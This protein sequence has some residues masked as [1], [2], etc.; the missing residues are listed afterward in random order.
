MEYIPILS[1]LSLNKN[2][3][4][5]SEKPTGDLVELENYIPSNE[6]LKTREGISEFSFT[7]GYNPSDDPNVLIHLRFEY[8][9]HLDCEINGANYMKVSAVSSICASTT[10][11]VEGAASLKMDYNDIPGAGGMLGVY[12]KNNTLPAGFPG[13]GGTGDCIISFWHKT[14]RTSGGVDY[15]LLMHDSESQVGGFSIKSVENV[16][17]TWVYRIT[18][19]AGTTSLYDT[20]RSQTS[21]WLHFGLWSCKTLNRCG[22]TI[23]D[24]STEFETQDSQINS[25]GGA[26][27]N[28]T[29]Q[30]WVCLD[31][32][33]AG[34][35]MDDF[36][37]QNEA[38]ATEA[39][40]IAKIHNMRNR[41]L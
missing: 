32:N 23:Y 35:M 26:A 15:A 37:V 11:F 4:K 30:L 17:R 2:I 36:I 3:K 20:E 19:S 18:N 22:L 12:R 6:I 8:G 27:A 24:K 39:A 34:V 28:G 40:I 29:N 21:N 9:V 31:R 14:T 10:V 7:G 1:P 16:G 13:Q 38:F 33:N 41:G 25:I 5:T